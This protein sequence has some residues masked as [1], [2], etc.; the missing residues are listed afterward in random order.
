M[1]EKANKF[2]RL[3]IYKCTLLS[4]NDFELNPEIRL[5]KDRYGVYTFEWTILPNSVG[6]C[7]MAETLAKGIKFNRLYSIDIMRFFTAVYETLEAFDNNDEYLPKEI[8]VTV[9]G[10]ALY[11][12]LKD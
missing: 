5:D 1:N 3:R 7:S 4:M 12:Q 2:D 6:L 10:Y 8:H 11:M 9:D